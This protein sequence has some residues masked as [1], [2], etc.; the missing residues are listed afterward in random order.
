M[1][2][3]FKSEKTVILAVLVLLAILL[4]GI[5]VYFLINKDKTEEPREP[6]H[7]LCLA[8]DEFADYPIDEKYAKEI[9][10]PKIPLIIFVRDSATNKEKF[11]FQINDIELRGPRPQL[12]KCGVYV[13]R[14]FN[15]D[16]KK[17]KQDPGYRE[18]LWR[19]GYDGVGENIL[20][21]AEKDMSGVFRAEFSGIF[22][23]DPNEKYLVL[24]KS[25]LGQDNYAL[26]VKDIN[27]LEDLFT[28]RLKDILE[29][30]PDIVPGS[31]GFGVWL[32]N[33]EY[34]CG[35]IFIGIRDTAYGCIKT[36]TWETEIFSSPTD[37]LA[38][39]ER[40]ITFK[41]WYL[42]YADI[43][44]FTGMDIITEQIIE[45]ARK[46][47]RQ[48]NLFVYN[49]ITRQKF[50]VA[51]AD[52]EWRFNIKW[53]SDTELEYELPNGEKKVYTIEE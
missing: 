35:Y 10:T 19:Y 52:P 3:N 38:G 12:R 27:T 18:E 15:Y 4:L 34:L 14:K 13:I 22:Q 16:P 53:L 33:G 48:K 20:L 45:E 32:E 43:P 37:L 29:G 17:T 21:L 49:L 8:D 30:H 41:S 36:G 1:K 39:V 2:I 31:F 47:G 25:Y 7:E 9:R 46:E 51:A 23:I 24:E 11:S 6:G 50:K 44:S 28:L 40:A 26:V 42:A 5:G